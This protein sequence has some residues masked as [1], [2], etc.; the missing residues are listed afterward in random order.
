MQ[1]IP[2]SIFCSSDHFYPTYRSRLSSSASK[3]HSV[4]KPFLVG[5]FDWT[6]Q[7][8]ERFRWGYFIVLL[9]AL[10]AVAIW[11]LPKR[12]WPWS[13]TLRDFF[14]C[15]CC[16]RRK[17]PRRE[18]GLDER[19]PYGRMSRSDDVSLTPPPTQSEDPFAKQDLEPSATLP[20]LE[21]YP[22]QTATGFRGAVTRTSV[23]DRTIR[24]RRWMFS[25]F[26][27]VLALP[28]FGIV[29][30]F[31]PTPISPFLSSL[32]TLETAPMFPSRTSSI[33]DL[34]WSLF[35]RTDSGCAF[36]EHNDGYT[37]HYPSDP[38]SLS[39]SAS[40]S[41]DPVVMLT[42]HAWNV[43]Q[44]TPFWVAD[45]ARDAF[46]ID[47][48]KFEDLPVVAFPQRGLELANG[49]LVGGE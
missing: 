28:L 8:Y 39:G 27:L 6:N 9:P 13:F 37:L 34:Y 10:V 32:S 7:Y 43:R 38:T 3:A 29:Y 26:V 4:N 47:K 45:D 2:E 48:L 22:P 5:E 17:R 46:D 42:R 16:R 33:G 19:G 30:S 49:T 36:V 24:I 21:T 41:G 23:L 25:L 15:R 44:E 35:G 12:W 14:S 31:M 11:F 1:F 20:V 40:G 18:R